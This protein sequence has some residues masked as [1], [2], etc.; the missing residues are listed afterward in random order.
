MLNETEYN[1][2]LTLWIAASLQQ[3]G[4]VNTVQAKQALA[5]VDGHWWDST[6]S[7][8]SKYMILKRHYTMGDHQTPHVIGLEN[9]LESGLDKGLV[10]ETAIGSDTVLLASSELSPLVTQASPTPLSLPSE[11]EGV[12]LDDVARLILEVDDGYAETFSHVPPA[13]WEQRIEHIH[14]QKI[15]DFAQQQDEQDLILLRQNNDK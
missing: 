11:V 9:G 4:A 1:Q 7:I 3:L 10:N 2:N 13:L 12:K 14:F 15:A 6:E 5:L 8:P